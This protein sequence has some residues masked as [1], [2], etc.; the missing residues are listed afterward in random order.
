MGV[1]LGGLGVTAIAAK[2][3]QLHF[4]QTELG[5]NYMPAE[6]IK[7]AGVALN[8]VSIFDLADIEK[9]AIK[10]LLIQE[11]EYGSAE[12]IKEVS[13]SSL[14]SFLMMATLSHI[15]IRRLLVKQAESVPQLLYD[16]CTFDV[17]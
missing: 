15:D 8:M 3:S 6:W 12:R 10:R 16:V 1:V 13:G 11:K 4:V 17:D 7:L 9:S 5:W 2:V 14:S